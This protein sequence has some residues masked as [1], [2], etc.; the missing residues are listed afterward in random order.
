MGKTINLISIDIHCKQTSQGWL[1]IGIIKLLDKL[2][3]II[4]IP[5][6]ILLL[7]KCSTVGLS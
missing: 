2:L 6:T 4:K 3:L 7:T 1:H 5:I